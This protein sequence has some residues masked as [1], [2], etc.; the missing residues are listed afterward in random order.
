MS[1]IEFNIAKG[2]GVE[3]YQRVLV[4][5]PANAVLVLL[6]LAD[7]SADGIEGLR[8]FDTVAAILAGGYDEVTNTGYAR[9]VLDNTDLSAWA[10]D[11]ANNSTLLTLPLVTFGSPDVDAGDILD[12]CVVAYDPDSTGGTDSALVPVSAHEMRIDGTAVPGIG[13]G[14]IF[15]L[16]GGWTIDV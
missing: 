10:P 6:A 7:G 1:A 13:T 12:I 11:D 14:I 2:R 3:L 5:D 15:D 4:S 8:D 9:I 16:S